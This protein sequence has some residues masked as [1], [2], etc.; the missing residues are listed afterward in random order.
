MTFRMDVFRA[1]LAALRWLPIGVLLLMPR[2]CDGQIN[3][4]PNPSFEEADTCAVQLGYLP[5]GVPLHWFSFSNT[6]DYFRSCVP[7]GSIN[8]VPQSGLV[9]QHPYEGGSYSGLL[10]YEFGNNNREMIGAELIEPL[11]VGE[12]YYASMWV[13]AGT[14]GNAVGNFAIC[15]NNIGML[16]TMDPYYWVTGM[17]PYGLRNYAQVYSPD[18]VTDTAG[19]TLVSGSFVADSA[20][21]YLAIGNHFTDANTLR[22]TIALGQYNMAYL[23]VDAICVSVDPMGC[24]LVTGVPEANS[25]LPSLYPNPAEGTLWVTGLGAGYANAWVLDPLGRMV[26]SGPVWGM[27]KMAIDVG[28]WPIGQYVLVLHGEE[29]RRSIRF[30]VMR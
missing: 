16:F 21:R 28:A 27:E 7:E 11:E 1:T 8:W 14:G 25:S 9:Y 29:G 19:W 12:T 20:Y 13:N 17:T 24:P 5:N 4:V 6:P 15:T 2:L 10:T 18:V 30:V 22:D 26:W 3:L 23:P